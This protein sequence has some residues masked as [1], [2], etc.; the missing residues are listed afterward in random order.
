MVKCVLSWDDHFGNV[1]GTQEGRVGQ[2]SRKRRTKRFGYIK[3][4]VSVV[5]YEIVHALKRKCRKLGILQQNPSILPAIE[6]LR[7]TDDTEKSFPI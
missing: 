3:W 1:S 4:R 7:R 6:G 5:G 2:S